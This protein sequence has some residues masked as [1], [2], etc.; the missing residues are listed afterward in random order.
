M[1]DINNSISLHK[2]P[3]KVFDSYFNCPLLYKLKTFK[4]SLFHYWK[5]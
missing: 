2:D 3:S 4:N 1:E 5:F